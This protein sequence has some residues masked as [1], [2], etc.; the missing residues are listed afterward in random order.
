VLSDPDGR[1]RT[2]RLLRDAKAAAKEQLD[3]NRV[4][5]E[6]LRDALLERDELIGDEILEVLRLAEGD[7]AAAVATLSPV[8]DGPTPP[9]DTDTRIRAWLLHAQ[10]S[11]AL[12]H[13]EQA[14]ASLGH[15]VD[16]AE[17]EDH[18]RSL[19]NAGTLGGALVARF[20]DWIDSSW[21]FLDELAQASLD[22]AVAVVS[23]MPALIE[24]L[25][26]RERVV[27]RYLPTMLTFEEIGSQLYI[28]VNTTK[29]HVRSIYRKLG[30]A[31]RR[32]AVRRARQL[33][34][35]RS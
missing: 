22:P 14:A 27:L 11:H 29:S 32:D 23:P 20:R 34:L 18:R 17:P 8:V 31:G 3:R 5:V 25:S 16:L 1:E 26:E 10:A 2:E 28:S 24:P 6:A 33:R 7:P 30:V 12:N 21:P 9:A 19:L 35:L 13:L 4:L 15:A